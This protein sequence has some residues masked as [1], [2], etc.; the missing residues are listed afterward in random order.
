[1]S[2]EN[3]EPGEKFWTARGTASGYLTFVGH[4]SQ[5]DLVLESHETGAALVLSAERAERELFPYVEPVEP[6][7][8][9]D[10]YERIRHDYLGQ[11]VEILA[12]FEGWHPASR[13]RGL[14]TTWVAYHTIVSDREALPKVTDEVSFRKIFS[15]RV[16]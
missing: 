9:G 10:L 13:D 14:T 6:L 11:T 5:G 12:V 15:R 1:M 3:P 7:K 2:V 4:L 8:R 16:K